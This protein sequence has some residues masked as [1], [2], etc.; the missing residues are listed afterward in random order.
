MKSGQDAIELTDQVLMFANELEVY[1]DANR[2]PDICNM[3][4]SLSGEAAKLK[5]LLTLS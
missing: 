4:Q 1:G 2:Y 3:A 5:Y